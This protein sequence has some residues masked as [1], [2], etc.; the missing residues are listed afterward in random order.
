MKQAAFN[1]WP[2]KEYRLSNGK[3][4]YKKISM[5]PLIILFLLIC[6]YFSMEMTGFKLETLFKRGDQFFV[7]LK[8]MFPPNL[9]FLSDVVKPLVDTIK[10]SIL[11]TLIGSILAVPIAVLAAS[12]LSKTILLSSLMKFSLSFIRT[13]PTLVTALI[14]TYIFGLG[15]FAGTIAIAIFTFSFVG[16]QLYEAIESAD[17]LPYEAMEAI[18]CGR[19]RS[20]IA[21]I[22]PQVIASY[23]SVSLYTFEGNVRHAAILGYVGAGGIGIILN[24]NIA[25]RQYDN[26]G[27]I[28]ICLFLTVAII[29]T[30]SRYLRRRLT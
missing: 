10:M 4:I 17:M 13:M 1:F 25:W 16:K 15:T 26:V 21:A 2:K 20:F 9:T 28:L 6:L 24:E 30:F 18:G 19:L 29:E 27:T 14:L 23:L 5:T 22:A 11:G 12:N 8:R 7:I 3:V